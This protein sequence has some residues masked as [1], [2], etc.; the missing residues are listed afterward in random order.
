MGS[1]RL[2]T[3]VLPALLLRRCP[4]THSCAIFRALTAR[5]QA[6]PAKDQRVLA[7][8]SAAPLDAVRH[9]LTRGVLAG[10]SATPLDTVAVEAVCR[11]AQGCGSRSCMLQRAASCRS[12]AAAQEAP[13]RRTTESRLIAWIRWSVLRKGRAS[14]SGSHRIQIP[15]V[16]TACLR[17]LGDAPGPV[18]RAAGP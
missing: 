15:W 13:P 8:H 2:C 4:S 6:R 1:R 10:H 3:H 5:S 7:S 18:A 9:W 17:G 16:A 14:S 12:T 11:S